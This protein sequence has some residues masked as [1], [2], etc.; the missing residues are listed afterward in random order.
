MSNLVE[1]LKK[2]HV[3]LIETL[4][5][6]K[7]LGVTSEEGNKTFQAAKQGLLEHL[8]KEDE[9]LYPVLNKAALQDEYLKQTLDLFAQDMDVVSK[10]VLAFFEKYSSGGSGIGFAK[11]FGRISATLV[12][13]VSKEEHIIYKKYEELQ[14]QTGS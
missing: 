2:E 7:A 1:E 6:V 5:M 14:S 11:D 12:Q 8:K 10:A 3:N 13:R 9:K 4:K